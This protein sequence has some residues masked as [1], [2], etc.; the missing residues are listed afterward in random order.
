MFYF[1]K[2]ARAVGAMYEPVQPDP[3]WIIGK[4]ALM[5]VRVMVRNGHTEIDPQ[6]WRIP[7]QWQG[8]HYQ[9]HDDE[10][11][12]LLVNSGGGFVEGDVSH[13]H[14]TVEDNARVL[15]TTTAS[16]KFYKCPAGEISREIVDVVVGENAL[17][18]LMPDEAIPFA[19]RRVHR[20][21]RVALRESS[22]LFA[23]DMISAGRVH[24]GDGEIFHFDSLTSEF[25]ILVDGRPVALDRIVAPDRAGVDALSRL[26]RGYLHMA[27]VFAYASDLPPDIENAIHEASQ[28]VE[29]CSIGVSRIGNL[30]TTRVLATE[31]WQAHEAIY[32]IWSVLRPSLAGKPAEPI[33][34]S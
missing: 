22:R 19:T 7:Y 11:F 26:W 12:M 8:Y 30:I 21:N 24:Y 28:D 18:E 3:D 29:G 14:A 20:I 5:N 32:N 1:W 6:S 13:F 27:N 25:E 16:S 33:R 34:K 17:V 31:T 4:Y 2:M 9:N 10:P 23:T 15:F